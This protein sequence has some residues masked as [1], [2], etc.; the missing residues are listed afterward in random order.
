M[1]VR[2]VWPHVSRRRRSDMNRCPFSH[3]PLIMRCWKKLMPNFNWIGD[4]GGGGRMAGKETHM[5]I[6]CVPAYP[7]IQGISEALQLKRVIWV[8]LG[9]WN[10]SWAAARAFYHISSI[11]PLGRYSTRV[12]KMYVRRSRTPVESSGHKDECFCTATTKEKHTWRSCHCGIR[13][14]ELGW[15]RFYGVDDLV[16]VV[17]KRSE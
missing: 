7:P 1:R 3:Q 10:F 6:S 15:N 17:G 16:R 5:K 13:L 14:S 12:V 9:I 2:P 4:V 8:S 11:S